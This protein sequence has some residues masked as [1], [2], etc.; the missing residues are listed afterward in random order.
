MIWSTSD[1]WRAAVAYAARM[2]AIPPT[3]PADT[4]DWE[5][6]HRAAVEGADWF[7]RRA[8]RQEA[9]DGKREAGGQGDVRAVHGRRERARP[10]DGDPGLYC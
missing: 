9:T 8:E 2:G 7:V 4:S 1:R 3:L 6:W 5:A 10:A